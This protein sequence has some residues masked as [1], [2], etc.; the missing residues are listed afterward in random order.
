MPTYCEIF[1]VFHSDSLRKQV[2]VALLKAAQDVLNEDPGADNHANRVAWAGKV[3]LNPYQMQ[4]KMLCA[5][6][7]NATIQSGTFTD[8][9][10]QFV[11][12]SLINTYANMGD[13]LDA[14]FPPGI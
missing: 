14:S 12:N 6:I 1:D 5:I 10:V 4:A 7:V 3:L 13:G 2:I 11:V 9:D 8:N